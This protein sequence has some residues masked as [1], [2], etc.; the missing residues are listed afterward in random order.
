MITVERPNLSEAW[1]ETLSRVLHAGGK[2][3]NVVTSWSGPREVPGVRHLIDGFVRSRPSGAT[4]WP[5]WPIQT[6]ANTIF[7]EELYEEELGKDALAQFCDWYLEGFEVSKA[8]APG[9]EYCHRLVAWEGPDGKTVN[10]LAEVAHKL[11]RYGD[12]DDR[13]RF[14][15]A[16]EVALENPVFDLR[17]QMPGRNADPYGFPCLSHISITVDGDDLHLTAL[18]RNQH[19]IRKAY[20]NYVGLT[21]LA[22][23]LCHHA[24]LAL[25][26]VTVVATHADAELNVAKGFGARAIRQLLEKAWAAVQGN[27][28]GDRTHVATALEGAAAR[29]LRPL[30]ANGLHVVGVDAVSVADFEADVSNDRDVL[31]RWFV[32]DE[33]AECRDDSERLA[34]RFAAKEATLK[35]MG[36]GI[37]GVDMTDVV[38]ATAANGSPSIE[39]RGAAGELAEAKGLTAFRCSLTHEEGF[40]I[41]IVI[42]HHSKD[43]QRMREQR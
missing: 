10:Q 39:L 22:R 27:I 2:A 41:A 29:Q 30:I 7:A 12:P 42:A 5:R 31:D 6:V 21:D 36:T 4:D 35:A 1:T 23:A 11:A 34:A 8:A 9:G 15:S 32:E 13:Y 28:K 26:S 14:S 33:L 43:T 17:T 38:V 16:Y 24:G 20:G 18:Y 25:G 40:A 3:V 19:L 37:R